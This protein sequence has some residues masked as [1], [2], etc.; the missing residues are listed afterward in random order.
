MTLFGESFG[1]RAI[2]WLLTETGVTQAWKDKYIDKIV[3]VEPAYGGCLKSAHMLWTGDPWNPGPHSAT[4]SLFW[5]TMPG[6]LA[7]MP[8]AGAYG[9]KPMIIG[10]N[11][12]TVDAR[13]L[14]AFLDKM[15]K[16]PEEGKKIYEFVEQ[17]VVMKDLIDPGVD[18]AVF[19]NTALPTPLTMKFNSSWDDAPVILNEPGD[20]LIDKDTMLWACN[21]WKS[22]HSVVCRDYQSTDPKW[23]HGSI[24]GQ[25]ES[26]NDIYNAVVQDGW[27][28][29]GNGIYSGPAGPDW[30]QR[31]RRILP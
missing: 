20:D 3:L 18:V 19:C 8:N 30:E 1:C 2:H 12:E 7:L 22:G 31:I 29:G 15:G 5:K 21:H 6:V 17:R 24:F 25:D 13:G 14:R 16:V 10:P 4:E 9:D 23:G 26:L 28:I 11:N 27:K